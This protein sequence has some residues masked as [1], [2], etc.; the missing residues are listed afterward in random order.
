MSITVRDYAGGR[1]EVDVRF[2][3]PNGE[4]FRRKLVSPVNSESGARRWGE[5]RERDLYHKA[6]ASGGDVGLRVVPTFDR[7]APRFIEEYATANHHKPSGI[8]SKQAVLDRYLLPTFGSKRLNE[9]TDADVQKLK[10]QLADK[11]P[12]TVNNILSV[13]SKMLKVATEWGEIVEMPVHIRLLRVQ[14]TEMLFYEPKDYE[15]LVRAAAEMGWQDELLVRLGGD[16]GLRR[17]EMLGVRDRDAD[18]GRHIL[19]VQ[20]NVV[21]GIEVATKG[22]KVR[23]VPLTVALEELLQRNVERGRGRLLQQR[24]GEEVTAKMLR[25]RMKHIQRRAGL[26]DNG[27]LHILRHTYCSHLAM[28]GVPVMEIQ[29][30]AGH[31]HLTTTLKYMHL[32]PGSEQR[33]AVVKLDRLRAGA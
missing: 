6:I 8:A 30:L 16:A 17:G 4:V 20:E 25:V 21:S 32:A 11:S 23:R 1:K 19:V 26:T 22:M 33:E 10:T 7:F 24:S 18:V 15:K 12:K 27:G 13:L 2:R 3:L 28:A 5:A 31:A 29:R 14:H 9:I